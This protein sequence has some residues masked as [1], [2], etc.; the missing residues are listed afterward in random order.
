M[1]TCVIQFLF[2]V[3]VVLE[4]VDFKLQQE[5]VCVSIE[6]LT[7]V[8]ALAFELVVANRKSV[9]FC[10]GESSSRHKQACSV[11]HTPCVF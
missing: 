2:A 1:I 5:A 11:S 6:K 8:T 7:L 3:L 4:I 9:F 10:C